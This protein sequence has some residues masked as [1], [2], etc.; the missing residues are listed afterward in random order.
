MAPATRKAVK[1][2]LIEKVRADEEIIAI[3]QDGGI[4][5]ISG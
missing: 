2:R 1:N 4:E 5:W 3:S